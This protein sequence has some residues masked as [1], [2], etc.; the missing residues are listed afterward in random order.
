MTSSAVETFALVKLALIIHTES[1]RECGES[2]A[3]VAAEL[4]PEPGP[5]TPGGSRD[6]SGAGGPKPSGLHLRSRFS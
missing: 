1:K 2:E 3:A 5:G 4:L 6:R